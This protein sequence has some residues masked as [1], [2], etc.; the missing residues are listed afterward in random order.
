MNSVFPYRNE[1]RGLRYCP[2]SV[3]FKKS[4]IDLINGAVFLLGKQA[5][6]PFDFFSYHEAVPKLQF[7]KQPPYNKKL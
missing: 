7:L 2:V 3:G 5:Y 6:G 1:G 4:R